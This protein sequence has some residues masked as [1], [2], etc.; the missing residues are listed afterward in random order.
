ME[1]MF[2]EKEK[3]RKEKKE[4]KKKQA[5]AVKA[6]RQMGGFQLD[7]LRQSERAILRQGQL[8]SQLWA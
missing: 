5:K 4:R 7:G 2:K 6:M 3:K 1:E 8:A